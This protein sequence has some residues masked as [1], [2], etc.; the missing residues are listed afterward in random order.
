MLTHT[1][2]KGEFASCKLGS[3]KEAMSADRNS[4]AEYLKA[5]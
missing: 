5:N 4:T 3:W 2:R 1:S